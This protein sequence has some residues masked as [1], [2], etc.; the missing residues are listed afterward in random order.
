M[1]VPFQCTGMLLV[2]K[3]I[4]FRLTEALFR[5]VRL[6]DWICRAV[7]DLF[8]FLSLLL[9]GC[10]AEEDVETCMF[11]LPVLSIIL[12]IFSLVLLTT[13]MV[14]QGIYVQNNNN[15]Q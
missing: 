1:V 6:L 3:C 2:D 15:N 11:S 8:M 9:S 12:D 7:S 4:L 14:Q 13:A 10:V 5:S